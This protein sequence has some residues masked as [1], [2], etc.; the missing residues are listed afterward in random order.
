[1]RSRRDADVHHR[2]DGRILGESI[3]IASP[4]RREDV[5]LL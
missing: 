2:R 1:L 3:V 4:A 5:R